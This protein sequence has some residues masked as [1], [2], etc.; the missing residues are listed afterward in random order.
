MEVITVI[1]WK[2]TVL[3]AIILMDHKV[4]AYSEAIFYKNFM[5]H[6]TLTTLNSASCVITIPW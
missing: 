4:P 6:T 5:L 3:P 1:F 2:K